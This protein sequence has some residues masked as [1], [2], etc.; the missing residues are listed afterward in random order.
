[1]SSIQKP[2]I[3]SFSLRLTC[4]RENKKLHFFLGK[5][6]EGSDIGAYYEIFNISGARGGFWSGSVKDREESRLTNF[7]FLK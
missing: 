5:V 4:I 3:F 6:G 7:V 2:A 1:M